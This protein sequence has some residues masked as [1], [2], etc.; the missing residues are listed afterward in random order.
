MIE[1]RLCCWCEQVTVTVQT[2]THDTGTEWHC[3]ECGNSYVLKPEEPGSYFAFFG[4]DI[5]AA[6]QSG[7]DRGL[8][9]LDL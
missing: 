9:A 1:E 4:P 8:K 5:D 6:V 3:L 2:R 7:I